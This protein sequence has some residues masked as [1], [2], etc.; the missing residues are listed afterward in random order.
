MTIQKEEKK[1]K[2]KKTGTREI[3]P[4]SKKLL[5]KVVF[6]VGNDSQ[7]LHTLVNQLA[8]KGADIALLCWQ[9][10]WETARTIKENVRG[11][12]REILLIGA[13]D[14]NASSSKQ[15][16]QA[17]TTELGRLDIFI[18]LSARKSNE[19]KSKAKSENTQQPDWSQP[20]WQL[21]GVVLEEMIYP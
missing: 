7:A 8:Q 4:P 16:I 21:I 15:L 20:N 12:G 3:T 6:L 14:Q 2:K 10:S 11:F 9:I 5:G 18:D 1:K 13:E 17:I 19:L